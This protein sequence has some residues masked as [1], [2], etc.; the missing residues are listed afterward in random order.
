[1]VGFPINP[2]TLFWVTQNSKNAK[3][4][5]TLT[6]KKWPPRIDPGGHSFV[7]L[8]ISIN[9]KPVFFSEVVTYR[10]KI[11]GHHQTE[12]EADIHETLLTRL[13]S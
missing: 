5:E 1:M 11:S 9:N 7:F 2:P 8:N 10:K 3:F 4:S 12:K 13:S 6:N